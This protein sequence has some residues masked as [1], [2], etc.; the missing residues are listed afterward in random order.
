MSQQDTLP[1][2]KL[3][4]GIAAGFGFIV[5]FIITVQLISQFGIG[6]HHEES[7][8][9]RSERLKPVGQVNVEGA[10]MVVQ[11][12]IPVVKQAPAVEQA[13]RAAKEIY[14]TVCMACHTTGVLGAPKYGDEA[15]W[16]NRITKGSDTLIQNAINGFNIMPPRGGNATLSDEEVKSVVQYML[17]AVGASSAVAA[18]EEAAPEAA[19]T[20]PATGEKVYQSA[21]AACH[22]MGIIGAPKFG[23]IDSWKPRITK[24]MDTLFTHALQGFQGETGV[25][26]P[27]GGQIQ[28]PDEDIKAAVAYMVS[29]VQ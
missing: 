1:V 8:E 21:C 13:P 28:L 19:P 29:Q 16:A 12:P 20:E 5:I 3:A 15:S 2:K 22:K 24:G 4:I 7:N 26:P 10:E 18:V 27:K 11:A 17:E 6:E 23:D 14:D 25:M 9:L